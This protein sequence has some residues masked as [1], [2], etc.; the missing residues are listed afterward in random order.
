MAIFSGDFTYEIDGEQIKTAEEFYKEVKKL[1]DYD[2]SIDGLH[3]IVT[4]KKESPFFLDEFLKD[5]DVSSLTKFLQDNKQSLEENK[6]YKTVSAPPFGEFIIRD[7]KGASSIFDK[8]QESNIQK[9][10]CEHTMCGQKECVH[11]YPKQ[12]TNLEGNYNYKLPV[13]GGVYKVQPTHYYY[14]STKMLDNIKEAEKLGIRAVKTE[15]KEPYKE[16]EGKLYY[17]L[18]WE[19]IEEMAKRMQHHKNGKY[20]LYNW[21]NNPMTPKGIE[22]MK[23]ALN[24]HHIEVMKGNYDDG[25]EVLG[26]IISYATNSMILWEQLR[27][28]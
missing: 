7:L 24:R 3:T 19:F 13:Y 18:S 5:N 27:N 6:E 17:E 16:T 23:Q 20:E 9:T 4:S 21:K 22:D 15:S 8:A 25:E 12:K 26:H 11:C 14:S 28:K 1:G 2:V 10:N